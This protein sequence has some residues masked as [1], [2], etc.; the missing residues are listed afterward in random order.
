MSEGIRSGVNW[1]RLNGRLRDSAKL[2]TNVVFAMPGGPMRRTWP[3]ASNAMSRCSTSSSLPITI[4]EISALTWDS[5]EAG[6]FM[7]RKV[8][9]AGGFF[10]GGGVS[11]P[12]TGGQ[13][14]S[15]GRRGPGLP[16]RIPENLH[17]G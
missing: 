17:S 13:K 4:L 15:G 12:E 1:I 10:G 9:G 16:G 7:E 11:V 2:W 3:R 14:A 8:E 5:R 6:W